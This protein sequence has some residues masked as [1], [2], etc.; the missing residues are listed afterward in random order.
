MP[1]LESDVFEVS[2]ELLEALV[3]DSE[4]RFDHRGDCQEHGYILEDGELCPQRLLKMVLKD[5]QQF[6]C[7]ECGQKV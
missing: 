4:C 5:H 7:S 3:D 6:F 1:R 2:G